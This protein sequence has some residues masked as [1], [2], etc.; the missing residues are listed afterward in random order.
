MSLSSSSKINV[1]SNYWR[2]ENDLDNG[3]GITTSY[4][5]SNVAISRNEDTIAVGSNY[6]SENLKIYRLVEDSDSLIHLAS[7]TLPDIHKLQFLAPTSSETSHDFKFLLSG[8]SNG[9]VYL[10]AIP[11]TENTVFENAE[12]I[13]RFNHSKH[14]QQSNY[15]HNSFNL[16]LNNGK[17]STTISALELTPK[18]WTS[19]PCNSMVSVY[20]HNL[21]FW[22]TSRSRS[23][24]SV[25]RTNGIANLA[26]NTISNSLTAVVGDFGLSLVDLRTGKH[27]NK[28]S[29]YLPPTASLSSSST[30][31]LTSSTTSFRTLSEVNKSPGYS[32]V[33]WSDHSEYHLATINPGANT[34][35]IW[36]IRK[37]ESGPLTTL[38]G[39]SDTVTQLKWTGDSLWTGDDDGYLA[40]WDLNDLNSLNG[41]E[42]TL[43]GKDFA[44][45][46]SCSYRSTS[47]PI[48]HSA[49]SYALRNVS[50]GNVTLGNHSRKPVKE[51]GSAIKISDKKIVSLDVSEMGEILCLDARSLSAHRVCDIRKEKLMKRISMHQTPP[52]DMNRKITGSKTKTNTTTHTNTN[53]RRDVKNNSS[54]TLDVSKRKSNRKTAC[55][56]ATSEGSTDTRDNLFDRHDETSSR[57]SSSRPTS[58]THKESVDFDANYSKIRKG[59]DHVH[60]HR[61]VSGDYPIDIQSDIDRMLQTMQTKIANNTVYI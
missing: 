60:N 51:C 19:A 2:I 45:R 15:H 47:S 61:D 28:T 59:F 46:T 16:L 26:L 7:I 42:C 35:H 9:I 30:S 8:H 25:I 49:N 37:N 21:F 3:G 57:Q 6:L 23:P 58:L 10:S 38:N 40:K 1:H 48:S 18:S 11:L 56:S 39:F 33:A 22:D 27:T 20:N 43:S 32:K 50:A 4:I 13:K 29:I 24:L 14:L 41:V 5:P 44:G 52:L 36:D 17:L 31:A 55:S 34:V 54:S 53:T 12:I